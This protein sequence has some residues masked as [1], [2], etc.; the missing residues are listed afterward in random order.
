LT[1]PGKTN[2]ELI[3]DLR[4][5]VAAL[6]ERANA[7][8]AALEDLKK[9]RDEV[10]EQGDRLTKLEVKL[11]HLEKQRGEEHGRAWAIKLAILSALIGSGFTILTQLLSRFLPIK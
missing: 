3:S 10:S 1:L 7:T 4:E 8:D 5:I 11:E 9:L 6:K 2:T